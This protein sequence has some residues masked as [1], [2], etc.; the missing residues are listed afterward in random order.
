MKSGSNSALSLATTQAKALK[1]FDIEKQHY[2]E[3]S[4]D[5]KSNANK[6]WFMHFKGSDALHNIREQDEAGS[7][8]VAVPESRLS[9][10]ETAKELCTLI[11]VLATG[12]K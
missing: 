7:A 3:G 5:E 1:L 2:D 9:V 4:K 12:H 11:P 6:S 8:D 10:W